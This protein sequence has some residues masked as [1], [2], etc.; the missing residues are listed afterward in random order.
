MI[1]R[2]I[3]MLAAGLLLIAS[4]A[5]RA[6]D[7]FPETLADAELAENFLKLALGSEFSEG[8]RDPDAYRIRKW[9]HAP[10]LLVFGN[11]NALHQRMM[12]D[13]AAELAALTGLRIGVANIAN[14]DI[15]IAELNER[16]TRTGLVYDDPEG[17][18]FHIRD[19]IMDNRVRWRGNFLVFVGS[20]DELT[21][22]AAKAGVT[23]A[24]QH[25][26]NG[27]E[28]FCYAESW[29]DRATSTF[30]FG[31]AFIRDDIP[32][33]RL[34]SCIVEELTQALGL[35]NDVPGA[36]FT[37]FND[38]W[39]ARQTELTVQDRLF[40]RLLYDR[41]MRPGFDRDEAREAALRILAELR[42]R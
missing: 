31:F 41:R 30:D 7:E 13:H 12:S 23:E 25:R 29:F 26:F 35:V 19:R 33:W 40:V 16:F 5:T 2:A 39:R 11:A 10:A 38:I 15:A 4:G 18:L 17:R 14:Q 9:R 34:Q 1:H 42:P 24:M 21:E 36:R 6:A 27:G 20:R 32:D 37:M 8:R 28:F 3:G 22:A